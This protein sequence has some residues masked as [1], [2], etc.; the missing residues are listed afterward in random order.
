MGQGV[1]GTLVD[2]VRGNAGCMWR[3]VAST[4]GER[5]ASRGLGCE[6]IL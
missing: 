3:C 1:D 5:E 4:S 6:A 2:Q